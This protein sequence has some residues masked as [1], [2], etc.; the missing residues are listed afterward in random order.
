MEKISTTTI[1]ENFL[2]QIKKVYTNIH[3]MYIGGAVRLTINAIKTSYL[4]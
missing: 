4:L 2:F 1:Q 3:N